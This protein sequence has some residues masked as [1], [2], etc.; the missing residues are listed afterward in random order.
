MQKPV[1]E[2]VTEGHAAIAPIDLDASAR[3]LSSFPELVQALDGASEAERVR[4]AG[5]LNRVL[6]AMRAPG[7][8]DEE[9]ELVMRALTAKALHDLEDREGRS[10]RKEAVETMLSSGFPH[11]LLLD[12]EDLAFAREF[13][14]ERQAAAADD[15]RSAWEDAMGRP[16]RL[17]A[18]LMIGGQVMSLAGIGASGGLGGL[19]DVVMVALGL[20]GLVCGATLWGTRP[21]DLN[22][23]TWGA[24]A[25]VT[26]ITGLVAA[27]ALHSWSVALAPA[28]LA[29]GLFVALGPLYEERADPPRPGEWD[30]MP[31]EDSWGP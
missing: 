6:I 2:L 10:C 19:G 31:N 14:R 4:L 13:R 22:T 9:A 25:V 11:A 17:G 24:F 28:S 26:A 12:P 30:Y 27:I 16:R 21:R 7:H 15:E 3:R 8:E 18:G 5:D 20:A 1:A 29:A 23:G